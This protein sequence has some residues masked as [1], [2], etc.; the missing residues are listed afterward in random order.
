MK[1]SYIM[2]IMGL[3]LF[4]TACQSTD[5][6]LPSWIPI[7]DA[8]DI[9]VNREIHEDQTTYII[10]ASTKQDLQE[11]HSF[12]NEAFQTWKRLQWNYQPIQQSLDIMVSNDDQQTRKI[13]V[14]TLPDFQPTTKKKNIRLQIIATE[15]IATKYS[16]SE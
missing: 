7:P 12:Y 10:S 14:F 6:N 3:F 15:K 9:Y 5:N 11:I 4:L 16:K 8:E 13:K 2:W 1:D